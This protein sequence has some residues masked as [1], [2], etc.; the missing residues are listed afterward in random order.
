VSIVTVFAFEAIGT[1]TAM[2]VIAADLGILEAYTWA[3]SAFFVTSL[4]AMVVGGLWSD[5]RGPRGPIIAGV[6][7]L[8]VGS[9][10]AGLATGLATLVAGRALQ[11]LG[12]GIII[13]GVYVLIARAYDVE[14]RPRAFSVLSAAWIVPSLVGP[15]V[16]GWLAETVSWRAVFLLIP[17]VVLLPV[18]LL[19]PR[20]REYQG[21]KR[22]ADV[23][24]RLVAGVV[25]AAGLFAFQSGLLQ[26]NATGIAIAGAGAIAV[27]LGSR[28]LLPGGALRFR[29]GLPA[30]VMMRG[31]LAGAFASAEVFIPLAL[32]ETRGLS[33]T[34]AGL[35]L[36]VSATLWSAGSYVQ[37]RL[38]G[39][40]DRSGA[41][42]AGAA[43]VTGALVV[44]PL[45]LVAT[46]PPWVAAPVWALAAFGMGLAIPSVSVQVMRLSPAESLGA[47]SSAVQIVDAL[48]VTVAVSVAGL[49]HAAAVASGGATA[50]T[51]ALIWLGSAALGVLTIALAGRMRPPLPAA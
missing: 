24:P 12:G 21:G 46:I 22:P 45:S 4:L 14:T 34:Q 25:A 13:V 30:S 37:S 27:V 6:I 19:F 39:A 18:V 9:A 5:A 40:A 47:N 35:I 49:G 43:V 17:V 11:G 10:V 48:G 23:R 42:R 32:T 2:P 50:L 16:A 15:V 31:L 1:A 51:Y 7:I 20:M 33:V 44:L 3:F 26:L 38:P 41:V 36:A 29:R 8:S 28:R